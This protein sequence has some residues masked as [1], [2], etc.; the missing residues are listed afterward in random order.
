M[1]TISTQSIENDSTQ[2]YTD[3]MKTYPTDGQWKLH[4]CMGSARKPRGVSD[5][6]INLKI[7]LVESV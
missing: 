4:A 7:P 6:Q 5:W 2:V 3:P 1:N